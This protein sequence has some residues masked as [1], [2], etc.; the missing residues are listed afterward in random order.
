MKVK[1]PFDAIPIETAVQLCDEIRSENQKEF[2]F[3]SLQCWGCSFSATGE[4]EKRCFSNEPGN[5]GCNLINERY[6]QRY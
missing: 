3:S 2:S 6:D 4:P 5:R 1:K